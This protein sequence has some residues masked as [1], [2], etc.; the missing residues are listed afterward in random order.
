MKYFSINLEGGAFVGLAQKTYGDFYLI[1]PTDYLS[2]FDSLIE[3][4]EINIET[5]KI[6]HNNY[7]EIISLYKKL[8]YNSI[9]SNFNKFNFG[10]TNE[11][12]KKELNYKFLFSN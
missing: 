9:I 3:D 10:S 7:I 5:E 2:L 11:N 8:G 12:Y 4:K 6:T 1:N